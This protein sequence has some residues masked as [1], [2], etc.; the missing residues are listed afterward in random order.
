MH[1]LLLL[2]YLG[3]IWIVYY[4][5]NKFDRGLLSDATYEESRLYVLW[6]QTRRFFLYF[7]IQAYVKYARPQ[8]CVILAIGP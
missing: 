7:P 4:I 8:D 2:V 3:I 6:F 1:L 5:L